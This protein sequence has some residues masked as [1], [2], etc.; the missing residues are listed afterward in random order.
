MSETQLAIL[1]R[2]LATGGSV[3]TYEATV[4][5]GICRLS[6]RVR[7]LEVRGW[8]IKKVREE[9]RGKHFTRYSL[10]NFQLGMQ[11]EEPADL[12]GL[13]CQPALRP[14]NVDEPIA[15]TPG[16]GTPS[17]RLDSTT[18]CN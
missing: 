17:G 11:F 16:G 18:T 10:A 1:F 2:Y 6:E 13:T 7:E 12:G 9:S 5:F 8:K 14:A 3:T 15:K 4:K